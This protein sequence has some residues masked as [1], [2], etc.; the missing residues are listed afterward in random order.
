MKETEKLRKLQALD[1]W[2]EGGSSNES[3]IFFLEM[4]MQK[5]KTPSLEFGYNETKHPK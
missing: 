3:I 4:T 5:Q 1:L 2:I